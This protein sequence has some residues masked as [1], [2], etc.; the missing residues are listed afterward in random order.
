MTTYIMIA[1][2]PEDEVIET[3]NG[4][5]KDAVSLG[6]SGSQMDS[7]IRHRRNV[8]YANELQ[9]QLRNVTREHRS[10]I[11]NVKDRI[12]QEVEILKETVRCDSDEDPLGLA[13][14]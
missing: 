14:V 12:L 5:E 1:N 2:D 3:T 8:I 6:I 11:Q 13:Y 4:N 7:N 10:N 9:K